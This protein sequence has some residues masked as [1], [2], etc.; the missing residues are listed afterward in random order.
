MNCNPFTYGHRFLIEEACKKVKQLI[1]FVV[2]EDKSLF[3]FEERFAMVVEGTKDI[4]NVIVVPSG[5]F[6]LSQKTFPEYFVKIE[7]D[8][9]SRN[10]ESDINIFAKGIA[11]KLN[12]KYRFVG[13]EKTDNVTAEYNK[14]MKKILPKHGIEL[15]EIP[16]KVGM[17]G[18]PISATCVR[19]LLDEGKFEEVREL[20]PQTTFDILMRT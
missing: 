4:K 11:P 8:D 2:E 15:I 5:E 6:I 14:A 17:N 1:V 10:A 7:N 13:E 12:I 9:V 16:R 18:K 20:V 19:A 3:S